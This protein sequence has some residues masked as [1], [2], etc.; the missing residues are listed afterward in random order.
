MHGQW[1]QEVEYSTGL[2]LKTLSFQVAVSNN[3]KLRIYVPY[4]QGLMW[5]NGQEI[6][7]RRYRGNATVIAH[8]SISRFLSHAK[9]GLKTA[10]ACIRNRLIA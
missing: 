1:S 7:F 8:S 3:G 9:D 10:G 6:G 2:C 4:V 5:E